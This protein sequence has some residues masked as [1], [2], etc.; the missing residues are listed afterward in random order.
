[1]LRIDFLPFLAMAFCFLSAEKKRLTSANKAEKN[2]DNL[3]IAPPTNLESPLARRFRVKATALTYRSYHK[4]KEMKRQLTLL[5]R[6][7]AS[8]AA[9]A[10]ATNSLSFAK[11]NS[12]NFGSEVQVSVCLP[13][14]DKDGKFCPPN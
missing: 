13:A 8:I 12:I 5:W 7:A 4:G 6:V 11:R 3:A 14:K 1:M 10:I 2:L 9:I